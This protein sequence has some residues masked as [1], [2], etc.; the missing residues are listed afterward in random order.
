MKEL[1]KEFKGI[2]E[3]KGYNF[4][5]LNKS[6]YAYIYQVENTTT[7]ALHYEVF[8]RQIN[9]RF[10][11]VSYPKSKS[12]GLWAW[13]KSNLTDAEYLYDELNIVLD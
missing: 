13:T 10:N 9:K 11:C 5:Q 7:K 1:K 4:K 3:V 2:G 8:K 12:F 6:P